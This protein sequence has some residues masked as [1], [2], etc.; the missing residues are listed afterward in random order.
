MMLLLFVLHS[1][2]ASILGGANICVSFLHGA[3][4]FTM[5]IGWVTATSRDDK[6]VAGEVSYPLYI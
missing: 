5:H 6:G 4:V 2:Q 3:V 1:V